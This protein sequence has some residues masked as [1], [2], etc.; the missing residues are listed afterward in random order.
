MRTVRYTTRVDE[1]VSYPAAKFAEEVDTYLADPDGWE[2]HGFHFVRG[3][4][5]ITI[6]L[7]TNAAIDKQCGFKGLSCAHIGGKNA[8]LNEERWRGGSSKSGL[9]LER[10]RQYLVSHEVGH[11]LGY[12]HV[13]CPGPGAP[14]PVMMQQTLGLHTCSPNTAITPTDVSG[15]RPRP[16]SRGR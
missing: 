16:V 3:S 11:V 8:W 15:L 9:A 6:H 1:G 5:G 13:K 7:S 4:G 12:E 14:A 2:A 10:Y